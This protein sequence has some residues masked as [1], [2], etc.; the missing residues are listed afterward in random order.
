MTRHTRGAFIASSAA[1]FA[2]V[3][4]VRSPAR[5][6][7]FS[8]KAGTNQ[9]VDH[10]LSVAMKDLWDAV[11]KDT[12]GRVDVTVFPN[13]QLG[14]DTAMLQQ[15]RSGALQIMTLDGG[16]LEAVVPVAA[17]QSVGFAFSD[18]AHA[19]RAFDGKLGAYVRGEIAG[20]GLHAFDKIW[21][22]GMR[23]ITTS[24]KPVH[25][26]GDIAGMKIRTPNSRMALDLFK[27]L[28][29]APTPINFSE[30]YTALQTRVVD[31]QENPLANIEFA[32]FFEVQ[33]NLSL[34]GHMWGGYWLLAENEWWNKLPADLQ[35]V[36]TRNASTVTDRQRSNVIKL[37]D[38][39][40]G[41]LKSQGMAVN[42][43]ST[44]DRTTMRAKLPDYYKRWK[45]EFGS[46]AWD[47]LESYSGKLA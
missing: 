17:I 43:L 4:F 16:I 13:N 21:E 8:G 27:S 34:S 23:Q 44:A 39:L 9:P 33:K 32:R 15:L 47:L 38:T 19:F 41:K 2:S 7:D 37:N 1:A 28:G 36:V 24:T 45:S 12:N 30:L 31:G 42:D 6:A 5:A 20:K 46:T 40:I 18:S 29:A 10:P 22:N 25:N 26:A 14:G 35:A 3:A 11:R